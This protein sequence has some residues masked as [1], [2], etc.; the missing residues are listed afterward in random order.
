MTLFTIILRNLSSISSLK[1]EVKLV[2]MLKAYEKTLKIW[3]LIC[4]KYTYLADSYISVSLYIFVDEDINLKEF[5]GRNFHFDETFFIFF[6]SL[7]LLMKSKLK[8]W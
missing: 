8:L 1:A 2:K 6:Y 5:Y 7:K 3:M 4:F